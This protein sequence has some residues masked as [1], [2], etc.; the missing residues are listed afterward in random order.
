MKV[1]LC[2]LLLLFTTSLFAQVQV[3][4]T[5][6]QMGSVFQLIVVDKDSVTANRHIDLTIAEMERIEDM[7]SEWRAHTPVSQINAQAGIQAVKVPQ[8]LIALTRRAIAYSQQSKGAFDVSIAAM[9][10]VWFFD[11][12]MQE[13]PSAKAIRESVKK[14]D[15]RA[16]QIDEKA[17]T[18]FLKKQGMK[19]GFGSI[20]KG[21]AAD[22]GRKFLQSLG[23]QAGIVNA[24]G[25]LTTWGTQLDGS[26]WRIGIEN[27]F[28]SEESLRILTLQN[29]A[30]ATS[31]SA[32]K[33]A[34]IK[35]KRYAHIINP[36]TGWP[37][38]GISS[39]T[40]WGASCEVANSLSTSV[41]ALGLKK[42]LR[43][44]KQHSTYNYIIVLDNGKQIELTQ[45]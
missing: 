38:S 11:G 12:S 15:Y 18:V 1:C 2:L 28:N 3:S 34:Q 26:P 44:L 41:M 17:S 45:F 21:Y 24:S 25:D 9:D 20:G 22:A 43:L 13:V 6:A 35:G 36:K 31:G 42:G 32:Q 7:L 19:I 29:S 5:F 30:V 37:S 27:P 40:V 39:I 10:K 8:E 4:R 16:I 14:V 23:V 33:Y